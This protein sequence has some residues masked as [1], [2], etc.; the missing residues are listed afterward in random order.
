MSSSHKVAKHKCAENG[1]PSTS[2]GLEKSALKHP[3][4]CPHR[5]D[6]HWYMCDVKRYVEFSN[7]NHNLHKYLKSNQ[8][9]YLHGDDTCCI[10]NSF[11][12]FMVVDI[13]KSGYIQVNDTK[14]YDD[15]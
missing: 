1:D 3:C 8:S 15:A 13:F 14:F 6:P 4:R 10:S 5:F 7:L 11:S 9:I 12:E 2:F